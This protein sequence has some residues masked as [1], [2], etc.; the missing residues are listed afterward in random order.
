MPSISKRI[1][2]N[3]SVSYQA[4]VRV[5]GYPPASAS[6]DRKTDAIK[7]AQRTEADMREDK[8]FPNTQAKK[9][10]V[11]D[12]IDR[13]LANLKGANPRRHHDVEHMLN[14]WKDEIGHCLL[15]H[16]HTEDILKGQQ[17]LMMR[18][19]LSKTGNLISPTISPSTVNRYR[20]ALHTAFKFGIK[21]LKWI[22]LNPVDDVDGLEEPQGRVRFLDKDEMTALLDACKASTCSIL[23]ALVVV[24][25]GTGARRA[26]IE[27]IRW[28]DIND[29]CTTVT[30]PK[31]KNKT[32][33]LIHLTG[34][35]HKVVRQMKD[36]RHNS[37][38]LFPS[39]RDAGRPINFQ[40][41]WSTA[42]KAAKLQNFC[43]HDLRHTH[44]S[45]MAMEGASTLQL[46]EALGHK[47][48][49]MVRRYAHL[50]QSHTA[51]MVSKTT[52]RMMGNVTI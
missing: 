51:G 17:K 46:A 11:A 15:S 24:G 31:T 27:N 37:I 45:Y 50:T 7:W 28:T 26:E 41:S 12:L 36:K 23:F 14:W 38:F 49:D 35:A 32:I 48:L 42:R 10:T 39:P 16:V 22:K 29:E 5:K 44:A 4:K 1:T 21:P 18:P 40:S 52:E 9:H 30:L 2:P 3:G 34:I 47:G 8:Y 43:F 20:V 33:R 6:F 13:Y 25:L 19:K